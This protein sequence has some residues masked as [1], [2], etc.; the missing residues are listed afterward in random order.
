MNAER[1]DVVG[2]SGG[3]EVDPFVVLA[4]AYDAG[5]VDVSLA[6]TTDREELRA[7]VKKARDGA[8][9]SD[10]G[11]DAIVYLFRSL[12]DEERVATHD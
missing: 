6:E 11:V 5:E 10:P 4:S 7:F 3:N 9:P 1:G 2:S 8:L 12:L